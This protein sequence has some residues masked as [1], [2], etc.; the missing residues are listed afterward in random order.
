METTVRDDNECKRAKVE[1][2]AMLRQVCV[3]VLARE[4]WL[5]AKWLGIELWL[6]R[7]CG[8]SGRCWI[9]T[10]YMTYANQTAH[11]IKLLAP[12]ESQQ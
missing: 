6:G 7:A 12:A 9:N 5:P 4:T 2:R 8:S 10:A 11:L 1:R 3:G